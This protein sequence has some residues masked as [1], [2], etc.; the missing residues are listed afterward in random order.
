MSL[1]EGDI[2]NLMRLRKNAKQIKEMKDK[3]IKLIYHVL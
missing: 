2:K 3:I 1:F